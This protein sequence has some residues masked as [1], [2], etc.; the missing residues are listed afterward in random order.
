MLWR[1]QASAMA[2]KSPCL[3]TVAV[4]SDS[5]RWSLE[6]SRISGIDPARGHHGLHAPNC[7][8]GIG[9]QPG[10]VG[11]PEQLG[12]MLRRAGALLA[13]DHRE[14][15]LMAVQIGHEHDS[16]FVE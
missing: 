8:L 9:Q 12:Q 2:T 13:A 7:K 4:L 11:E 5:Q 16:R 6:K 1:A 3:R 15:V 10:L 14:V